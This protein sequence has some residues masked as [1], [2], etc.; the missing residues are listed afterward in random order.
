[1]WVKL[2]VN[3]GDIRQFIVPLASQHRIEKT[4]GNALALLPAKDKFEEIG[5][6]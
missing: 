1:M 4:E 6:R 5:N 3:E 2:T